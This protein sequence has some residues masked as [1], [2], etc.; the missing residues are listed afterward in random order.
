MPISNGC[1][2]PPTLDYIRWQSSRHDPRWHYMHQSSAFRETPS[3][4]RGP[5]PAGKKTNRAFGTLPECP[6]HGIG[7]DGRRDGFAH[8]SCIGG[9][10]QVR[11]S[12]PVLQD[13]LNGGH[14]FGSSLAVDG[15]LLSLE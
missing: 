13:A 7:S 10:S 14:K 4:G 11:G 3:P 8:L 9:A 1:P 6:I 5:A 12:G 2:P 15:V